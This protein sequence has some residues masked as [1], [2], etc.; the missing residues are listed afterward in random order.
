MHEHVS[1]LLEEVKTR[2]LALSEFGLKCRRARMLYLDEKMCALRTSL[3]KLLSQRS[4][5]R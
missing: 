2:A 1:L 3:P 5:R 4:Q